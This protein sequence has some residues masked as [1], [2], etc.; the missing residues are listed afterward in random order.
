ML[1]CISIKKQ[2][3]HPFIPATRKEYNM[4][5]AT[6]FKRTRNASKIFEKISHPE[7]ISG[8]AAEQFCTNLGDLFLRYASECAKLE[9]PPRPSLKGSARA[10]QIRRSVANRLHR[11]NILSALPRRTAAEMRPANSL[12]VTRFGVFRRV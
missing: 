8:Y 4:K 7:D 10:G 3:A 1:F 6:F 9:N 12:V 2:N 5:K 11:F